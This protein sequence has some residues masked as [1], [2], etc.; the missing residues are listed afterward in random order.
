MFEYRTQNPDRERTTR[1]GGLDLVV[2]LTRDQAEAIGEDVFPLMEA[3]NTALVSLAAQ[4]TGAD[5]VIPADVIAS[6]PEGFGVLWEDR[7]VSRGTAWAETALR[8]VSGLLALLTGVRE[9]TLRDLAAGGYSHA[10]LASLMGTSRS[11][12]QSRRTALAEPSP[13]ELWATGGHGPVDHP[14]Q[15]VPDGVREW[16]MRWPGYTPVDITPAELRADALAVDVPDWVADPQADPAE[17]SGQEWNRRIGAAVVPFS[18]DHHGPMNPTGR[19]GRTGR[20]LAAWGE[21]EAVDSVLVT[22]TGADRK[23]LLIQRDDTGRWATPGGMREK[24]GESRI[25]AGLRELREE[26]G[27]AV[28]EGRGEVVYAGYVDDWRC[29]D[30]A[31]ICTTVVLYVVD[32]ELPATGADDAL[33]AAWWPAPD[34]DTLAAALDTAGGLSEAH[35]PLIAAALKNLA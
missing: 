9:A 18:C 32:T 15:P 30:R 7:P 12:A 14:G 10:S 3:L 17:I 2:S 1:L 31:W 27:I 25:A 29:T 19:T 26:T 21:N 20:N 5:P 13:A 16:G 24:N 4:R 34:M 11:T 23:V 35:R 22:G 28:P 8:E 33:A 6:R